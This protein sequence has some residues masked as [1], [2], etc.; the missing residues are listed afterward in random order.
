MVMHA[1]VRTEQGRL[2]EADEAFRRAL[3]LLTERGFDLSPAMGI[4]HIGMAGLR[5]ERD[6]LDGASCA[7]RGVELAERTGDASTLV[8]RHLSRNERARGDEEGALRRPLKRSAS[9]ATGADL[10]IAIALA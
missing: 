2:R 4:V 3:R 5:Y 7:G 8:G 10:Q 9:P 6:D 1:R